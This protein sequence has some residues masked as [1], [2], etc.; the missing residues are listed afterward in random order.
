MSQL[1]PEA[2][3]REH[4]DRF[5]NYGFI[6]TIGDLEHVHDLRDGGIGM[7]FRVAVPAIDCMPG[8]A[9]LCEEVLDLI[10]RTMP[11]EYTCQVVRRTTSNIRAPMQ[12]YAEVESVGEM[13]DSLCQARLDHFA[14]ACRDGFVPDNKALNFYPAAEE[15]YFFISTPDL[16]RFSA[17]K[18]LRGDAEFARQI[19]EFRTVVA[20]IKGVFLDYNLSCTAMNG[21]AF[22]QYVVSVLNSRMIEEHDFQPKV[23]G[24]Q[25]SEAISNAVS[26][27]GIDSLAGFYSTHADTQTHFRCVSMVWQ[28]DGVKAG[29]IDSI[30]ASERDCTFVTTVRILNTREVT[31]GLKVKRWVTSKMRMGSV[32]AEEIDELDASIGDALRRVV[33]G[34]RFV[35]ARLNVIV[36]APSAI[37][38]A[39]RAA[40]VVS[41]F[42]R[43]GMP[44]VDVETDIGA[45]LIINGCLPFPRKVYERG[46]SRARRMLSADVAALTP[47]GGTWPGTR[48]KPFALYC[49]RQGR[50]FLFNPLVSERNTNWLAIADS[51]SGKSF[52]VNDFLT[53]TARLPGA[54]QFVVSVKPDYRK[55]ASQFGIEIDLNL[56]G[57]G[58]KSISPFWGEPTPSALDLWIT[59]V[60][61][62]VKES[63]TTDA[64]A[65]IKHEIS[66]AVTTAAL[67]NWQ[68]S[69][70][71][72]ELQL[73]DIQL[74][75][76]NSSSATGHMLARR[77]FDYVDNGRFAKLFQGPSVIRPGKH[78][79]IFFNLRNIMATDA[80][81]TALMCVMRTIDSVMSDEV[82]RGV[83]KITVFDE[84]WSL[85]ASEF[86]AHFVDRAVRTYR[87]LGGSVG[88]VTQDHRDL[89]TP[90]GRA[91]L[92]NTATKIILPTDASTT[93][94]L[95]NFMDLNGAER[96]AI[97]SLRMVKGVYSEFFIS[98]AG[99]GSTVARL[100]PFPLMYAMNTTA[101]EDES[102]QMAMLRDGMT[103]PQMLEAFASQ[104]PRGVNA[105]SAHQVTGGS[106]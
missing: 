21:P 84:G 13:A 55:F 69:G 102:I 98:M 94:S 63:R 105:Q 42:A 39:D 104:Y 11:S 86:G 23:D 74:E 30:V 48:H 1:S 80:G 34:E 29:M 81:P 92:G 88:F 95:P 51:G 18:L 91:V 16:N 65:D 3:A 15:L 82:L 49:N 9:A 6:G 54:Y 70:G 76:A 27:E 87:S 5:L 62:M 44:Y 53:Q 56:S 85:I 90:M 22:V 57:E 52:F 37:A 64:G 50:P 24:D 93:A 32:N 14:Q 12:A 78:R 43:S 19:Q 67:R 20:S 61:G 26:I 36:T 68:G 7:A 71:E 38:V 33:N 40:A 99:V 4:L 96:A 10:Y 46:F 103:H 79:N 8:G 60:L 59:I 106:L 100:V 2:L 73:I 41:K 35:E 72:R 17:S 47:L 25:V 83:P 45:S 75:L 66:V 97:A 77:L 58:A 31:V 28:P 101:P 89:D